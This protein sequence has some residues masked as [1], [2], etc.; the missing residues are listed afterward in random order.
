MVPSKIQE[1]KDLI[2][3][4]GTQWTRTLAAEVLASSTKGQVHRC[5]QEMMGAER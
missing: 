5:M 4:L 3:R 2:L 1:A